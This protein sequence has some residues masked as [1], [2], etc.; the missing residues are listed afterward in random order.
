MTAT[1][2][3][4][5]TMKH[6]KDSDHTVGHDAA[7]AAALIVLE[8]FFPHCPNGMAEAI[9]ER[10]CEIIE[11]AIESAGTVRWRINNEPSEN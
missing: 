6:R 2:D 4:I 10:L 8:E 9:H 1:N 7:V 3:G 11:T 5:R